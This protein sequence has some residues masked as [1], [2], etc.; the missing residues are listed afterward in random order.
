LRGLFNDGLHQY[1]VSPWIV[2]YLCNGHHSTVS[3]GRPEQ[4]SV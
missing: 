1:N 4:E 3:Q 2:E